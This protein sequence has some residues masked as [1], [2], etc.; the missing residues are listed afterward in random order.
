MFSG[1]SSRAAAHRA[2]SRLAASVRCSISSANTLPTTWT[3]SGLRSGS[4]V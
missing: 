4:S 2:F 3:A 1:V